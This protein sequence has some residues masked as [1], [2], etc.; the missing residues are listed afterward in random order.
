MANIDNAQ[1]IRDENL[2]ARLDRIPINRTIGWLIALLG[3][4][5]ILEAFDIGIIALV[6]LFLRTN[7][8]LSPSNQGLIG[9][10]GTLGIVVGMLPAGRLADLYG[11]KGTLIAGI[12]LFSVFTAASAASSNYLELALFRF[13]AGLGQ[14]AVF[15]V[16]YLLLCEFVNKKWRGTAVSLSS[17]LLAFTYALNM[18]IGAWVHQTFPPD[19]AWRVLLSFGALPLLVVP[20]VWWFLP[21]SPRILLK[22]GQADVVQAFVERLEDESGLAHDT[23]IIDEKSLH[24]LEVTEGKRVRV[25]DLLRPPYLKR[26]FVSFSAL[27]SPF[28]V[29]YV[30]FIYGPV[31]IHRMGANEHDALL[32]TSGLILIGMF[33]VALAGPV[34]DMFSRRSTVVGVMTIA[35]ISTFALGRTDLP[36]AAIVIAAACT[37]FF[38]GAG[39]PPAKL[40]M[41][42][43]FPTRLRATGAMSGES[44]SRFLTGVMLVYFIP[45]LLQTLGMPLLFLILA[46][47]TEI[48]VLPILFMGKQTSGISVEESGTDIAALSLLGG[49]EAGIDMQGVRAVAAARNDY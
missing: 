49:D 4:V 32:Y 47:L 40:Y 41:A 38:V 26:C 19:I 6:I 23:S 25:S 21:E 27:L 22:R 36:Q 31:I 34:G 20:V 11:R 42:E 8:H 17:S 35:A 7:W 18:A 33:G 2:L 9:S 37:W 15:P 48:C 16:P 10:A 14:G 24:V 39:F 30:T 45:I 29:F 12:V 43:Q 3:A 5:W 1:I 46:I 13:I 44:F 28:I